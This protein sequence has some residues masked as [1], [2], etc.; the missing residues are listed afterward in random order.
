[1]F[2]VAYGSTYKENISWV[3]TLAD[4]LWTYKVLR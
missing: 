3:T 2:L 1:M 4:R